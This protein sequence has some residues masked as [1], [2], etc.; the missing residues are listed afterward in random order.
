MNKYTTFDTVLELELTGTYAHFRKFYTNA[1]SLTYSIPPRTGICGLVASILEMP[2]DSYYDLLSSENLGISVALPGDSANRKQFYTMNYMDDKRPI[3]DIGMH[4]QCRLELL[5]P[6]PGKTLLWKVYLGF[7]QDRSQEFKALEE[8]IIAQNLGYN[9]YLGQR[10]FKAGISLIRKYNASEFK[11]VDSSEYVDSVIDK[12]RVIDISTESCHLSMER[13]PL[14]QE[15]QQK[16]KS[17]YRKSIRFADVL[18]ET[19]GKRLTGKFQDLIELS[20]ES[21]TRIAFL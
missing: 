1:S 5:M 9:I 14:E 19:T 18:I 2:R 3:F 20:V 10:Q 15:L 12:D 7:N 17:T 13:M 4:K 6:A 21:Q 16:G 11:Q 8:R